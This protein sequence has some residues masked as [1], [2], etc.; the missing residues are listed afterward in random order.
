MKMKKLLFAL[1]AGILTFGAVSCSDD[2]NNQQAV[3]TTSG[4][5]TIN[6]GN[7][8]AKIPGTI[9]AYDFESG[10]ATDPLQCA[11][12]AKN[13]I[14]LGDTPN[15]AIIDGNRMYVAVS[16]SNLVWIL[17]ANTLEVLGSVHPEGDVAE[18]R[19]LAAKD[20]KV[21]VSMYSGHVAVIDEKTMKIEKTVKV[22]PNPEGLAIAG[23][24]LYVA[25][26][27]GN[28]YLNGNVDGYISVIDLK[29]FTEKKI[30]DVTKYLN[31]T[32]VV[33]NGTD[34]FAIC[35][36]NYGDIPA[37]VFK[38]SSATPQ[39]V[40][41]GT[42][43]AISGNTLYVGNAPYGLAVS[44]YTYKKYNAST[45]AEA[46]DMIS[47]EKPAY[48]SAITVDS[49]T[50][51]IL[52]LSYQLSSAG[53]AEY[54]LPCYGLIYESDG[55]YKSRFDCGVGAIAAVFVHEEK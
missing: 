48:P 35:M 14:E 27:D 13:G 47:G 22:G 7:Q 20:G 53:Y 17:D 51:D 25:N 40:C 5:Y 15:D 8:S 50:G 38:I 44:D 31:P 10:D 33:S 19:A 45:G 34:V 36:G 1:M 37:K 30:Q 24:S 46:G 41:H 49:L 32:K 43:M 26:S 4:I 2:D 9:T 12:K 6:S 42:M 39:E 29:T 18:P 21:Y 55:K 11:F 23:N 28:N 3:V 54:R 16:K 52:L